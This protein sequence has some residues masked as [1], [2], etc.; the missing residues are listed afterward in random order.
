MRAVTATLCVLATLLLVGC[1]VF[2]EREPRQVYQLPGSQLPASQAPVSE[3]VLRVARP[4]VDE[5]QGGTDIVVA[6]DAITLQSY[7]QARWSAPVPVL[8]RDH[9]ME[10]FLRDGR[11]ARV[12]SDQE[13]ISADLQL[14]G[15]LRTYR[16]QY[17][18]GEPFAMIV[19]DAHLIDLSAN[20]LVGSQRFEVREALVGTSVEQ[21]VM[22]LWRA[23]ERLSSELVEWAVD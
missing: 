4:A 13:G 22:A 23:T 1:T 14:G 17:E 16:I 3:R 9:L 2:P 10:A 5:V 11:L 12:V 18:Q 8:L 19:F 6:P 15:Q 21:A 20:R 7:G